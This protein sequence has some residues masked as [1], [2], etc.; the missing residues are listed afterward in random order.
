MKRWSFLIDVTRLS[1][2]SSAVE[3]KAKE[4]IETLGKPDYE[5]AIYS[6]KTTFYQKKNRWLKND[7]SIPRQDWG[8]DLDNLLKQ[9]FDGL[10]PI[11]GYRKNWTGTKE[12]SGT[13]DANIVSVYAEKL[14]SGSEKDSLGII[15]ELLHQSE[16]TE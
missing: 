1:D 7:P 15:I 16:S 12:N 2:V 14:N 5:K 8:I 4:A 11:I 3:E 13:L 6:V 9:V 10:G